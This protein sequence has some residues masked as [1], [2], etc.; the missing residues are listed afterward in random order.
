MSSRNPVEI[1][2][3]SGE[4]SEYAPT[5]K[6]AR[7]RAKLDTLSDIKREMSKVYRETRSGILETQDATKLV[8]MLAAVGKIIESS[9]IEKRIE[10]LEGKR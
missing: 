8:W 5:G 9:D 10:I 2:N 4:V 6:P 1:D 7:Y 3:A